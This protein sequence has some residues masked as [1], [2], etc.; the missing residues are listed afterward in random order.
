MVKKVKKK[1]DCKAC[2][3]CETRRHVIKPE[4]HY[5]GDRPDLFILSDS[6]SIADD[7]SGKIMCTDTMLRKVLQEVTDEYV[8]A[9]AVA[10]YSKS[11]PNE[12]A[13]EACKR[14]WKSTVSVCKPKLI[15]AMGDY[16]AEAILGRPVKMIKM[17]GHSSTTEIDGEKYTVIYCLN[18]SYILKDKLE[19]SYK[20]WFDTW[21]LIQHTVKN[22]TGRRPTIERLF[23]VSSILQFLDAINTRQHSPISYD[24]ETWGDKNALRPDLCGDFKI[25]SVG[26]GIGNIGYSFL[27]DSVEKFVNSKI[28]DAWQKFLKTKTVKKVAQN[29]KYEHKCNIKRFG[30]TTPLS[31]TMLAMNQIDELAPA[32]LAAISSYCRIPWAGYKDDMADIQKDPSKIPIDRLL[33]Y[34]ALEGVMT[35]QCWNILKEQIRERGLTTVLNMQQ[36]FAQNLAQ[37][38]MNGFFVDNKALVS[39]RKSLKKQLY[40]ADVE[41]RT[42]PEIKEAE[43][44]NEKNIKSFKKGDKFNASSPVQMKHLCLDILKLPVKPEVNYKNGE[45]KEK[46]KFD[47]TVLTPLENDY[48]IVAS[49]GKARSLAS[50]FTGFLNKYEH[51]LGPDG[52]I[53]TQYGQVVVV[54]QRL[55][56]TQPNLQNIPTE[57]ILRSIF[58]SRWKNGWIIAADYQQ[59]E[60]RLLAGWSGDVN[61]CKALND[62]LDLHRFVSSMIYSVKY[63]DVTDIQRSIGKRR[64]LGSMYGQTA[65]GLA[66]ACNI[67][68]VEAERIVYIYDKSFPGVYEF[69]KE[70][71]K[72]AMKYGVVKDLFGAERH[73]ANAMSSNK[74]KRNR[75]LRQA[76]NFPIQST[77]NKFHLI[78]SVVLEHYL[79]TKGIKACIIGVEHDKLYIDCAEDELERTIAITNEAMLCHNTAPYWKDMPV[80]MKVDYKYGKNLYEMQKWTGEKGLWD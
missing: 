9:D 15:V 79:L 11:K 65:A 40:K 74:G 51:F 67:S 6:P 75:A 12:K 25:L 63:E 52:C 20:T 46:W 69:R 22:G 80:P 49:L 55:N 30:F 8:I 16:A 70:R 31:D 3:R 64:N 13:I 62:G 14:R 5:L 42:Y 36:Q 27:F 44:W 38:E 78:A 61:M 43:K 72:E 32:N 47:K 33:E 19:S 73:L 34:S 17:A 45:R 26:V 21:D 2:V 53:H 41:F 28:S 71:Q 58:I 77:G 29:A 66:H 18:P 24:Y 35:I 23:T 48:P 57:S 4:I 39:V 68:M 59:L 56:S 50:M 76:S 10:C 54:T 60:P 1:V 7:A 37:I